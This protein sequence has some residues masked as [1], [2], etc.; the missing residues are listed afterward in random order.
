MPL[1]L[2]LTRKFKMTQ[3]SRKFNLVDALTN[4]ALVC[5]I[6]A[7]PYT[8]K[9]KSFGGKVGSKDMWPMTN[10]S[11]SHNDTTYMLGKWYWLNIKVD[12]IHPVP[13]QT[14]TYGNYPLYMNNGSYEAILMSSKNGR[15]A[16]MYIRPSTLQVIDKDGNGIQENELFDGLKELDEV[17]E[18]RDKLLTYSPKEWMTST[19]SAGE[20]PGES[21]NLFN[22]KALAEKI[23]SGD[24]IYEKVE[25][26]DPET[27]ENYYLLEDEE[28][29]KAVYKRI[30]RR[31]G[32]ELGSMARAIET[33]YIYSFAGGT[34]FITPAEDGELTVKI[35][36]TFNRGQD[37]KIGHL[38]W[39]HTQWSLGKAYNRLNNSMFIGPGA[40]EVTIV[41]ANPQPVKF[42]EVDTVAYN[43]EQFAFPALWNLIQHRG[44]DAVMTHDNT[45]ILR[46]I[47]GKISIYANPVTRH[48][49]TK[50]PTM[51]K[52]GTNDSIVQQDPILR[53]M[54]HGTQ[55][56]DATR[57]GQIAP[58]FGSGFNTPPRLPFQGQ[59]NG[60]S[61]AQTMGHN[62]RGTHPSYDLPK[63]PA[64]VSSIPGGFDPQWPTG[65]RSNVRD[66]PIYT[67]AQW[68]MMTEMNSTRR[69]ATDY[70]QFT[71]IRTLLV[72][73]AAN[74]GSTA[75]RATAEAMLKVLQLSTIAT[76]EED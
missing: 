26:M 69:M 16:K 67:Q 12:E 15:T 24:W 35:A 29:Q 32:A 13:I 31:I 59:W 11:I 21:V 7:L 66:L 4:E 68:D 64:G 51:Q 65:T 53:A 71:T 37:S 6:N 49:W 58:T 36:N 18:V 45:T 50:E 56:G 30:V 60:W 19:M 44:L 38:F 62:P 33:M 74:G 2:V 5:K 42:T 57:F 54:A 75:N 20:N 72:D 76:D 1:T 46:T 27:A 39:L 9:V 43:D 40:E 55:A 23:M 10:V 28:S 3:L 25:D 61:T 22:T 48:S 70:V 14:G 34:I 47:G 73:V 63:I 41:G 17:T 52:G 8:I